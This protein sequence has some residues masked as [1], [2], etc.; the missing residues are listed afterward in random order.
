MSLVW[1]C[2]LSI[3]AYVRAGRTTT[4]PAAAC[5][6]CGT[7]LAPAGGYFRQ[8]RTN[9]ERYQ[10]WIERRRCKPCNATHALLPDFVVA[11][12]ADTVDDI[13]AAIDGST[14]TLPA[15][16]VAGW[17]R[18]FRQNRPALRSGLAAATVAFGGSPALGD[19]REALE[20]LRAVLVDRWDDGFPTSWR[21]LNVMSGMSWVQSRVKSFW[22]GVGRVP[23]PARAP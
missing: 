10:I 23:A 18:R 4:V 22:T 21:L 8:L 17:R 11:N 6:T 3:P 19:V 16:T 5:P 1:P 20:E 13:A 12:H 2:L 15:T 7:Q 14:T 9:G